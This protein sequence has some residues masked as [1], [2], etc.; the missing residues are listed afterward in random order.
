[1]KKFAYFAKLIS[2]IMLLAAFGCEPIA[3]QFPRSASS[4]SYYAQYTPVKIEIIPL[5][6]FIYVGEEGDDTMQL[7]VYLS[8]LDDFN[9][10]IKSPAVFRFELYERIPRR[11]EPKGRR[12]IIWPDFDLNYPSENN[13]YWRDFLRAYEFNF[14]FH[15]EQG[16]DYILQATCICPNGKRLSNEFAILPAR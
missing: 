11:A 16:T 6:E 1:M 9:S 3:D 5:T 14:D 7:R 12:I 13:K 8:V 10:Q 4:F 2:I 15:P